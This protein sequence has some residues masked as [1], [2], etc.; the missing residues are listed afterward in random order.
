[1]RR[2]RRLL[3]YAARYRTGWALILCATL[4]STAFTLLQPWPVKVLV[5][6][7]LG[8]SPRS[9]ALASIT[10][11]LPGAETQQGLLVWVV[12]AG[13]GVFVASS[14]LEVVLTTAWVK[15]GQRVVYDL[16]QDLFANVQ[17]RSLIFHSNNS[18]GDSLSRITG[19]SWSVHTV[20]DTLLFAPAHALITS[21]GVL[22]VMWRLDPSL[23]LLS[24]AVVPF[25]AGSSLLLG[26]PIRL[27]A[28]AR[29]EVESHIYS[30]VQQ[31][32]AGIPVVQLFA[33][34]GREHARFREY[35]GAAIKAQRRSALVQN[36][37]GLASGLIATMGTAGV[38]WVGANHVIQGTLSIGSILV[39]LSYLGVLQAQLKAFTGIY[40][41]LQGAG[42]SVDRVMEILEVE[43]EVKDKPAAYPLPPSRGHVRFSNVSF[44]YD[45]T[46]PD[47]LALRG[48]T[49][50]VSPG[51]TVA[52]VGPTGAGK[53][54]L[55]GMI[56]RFFDPSTGGVL[57]DGH[58]LREVQLRSLREQV[59]LVLQEPFLFP[60]S[61]AE[62]IAY[63]CPQASIEQIE[64]AA[65]AANAH[66]FIEQLPEGYNTVIGERGATL[67]GGEKQRISIARALLKDAPILILD[68]P[69]SA[70]D[71]QTEGEL[72][73]AVER[74][75][76][77]RT[78]FIIAH[79]LST[80]RN[81][82]TIIVLREGKVV[83][84]G[85]HQHLLMSG[86][87]YS[88]MYSLQ[89]EQRPGIRQRAVAVET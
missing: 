76:K 74:L 86:G 60:L 71:A 87:I 65:K 36:L 20:I 48:V 44:A 77:G 4:L 72:M 6:N 30:H 2:Y 7:V 78:T 31:T 14:A 32:L 10:S 1:M 43:E 82:D 25:M 22:A 70:L 16:A 89:Q 18:V 69:T 57:I 68:E 47:R 27:A 46:Q 45:P 19:D 29:R 9:S 55:V 12:V 5:D 13:L 51:Q 63:G 42:A 59:S 53:S 11:I 35:T 39:F 8:D 28:R 54:T 61:I 75:M 21:A 81:A 58:D 41:A 64:R 62:N 67:S 73:Q 15:V 33:Q 49:L 17:R 88:R 52:I 83:Q 56:P 23:T 80:I 85:S 66:T 26:K 79:R 34:E 84:T 38:L 50:D 3:Q 40:S 37:N 24:V